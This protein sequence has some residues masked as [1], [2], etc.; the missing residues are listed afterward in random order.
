MAIIRMATENEKHRCMEI[1]DMLMEL[2]RDDGGSPIDAISDAVSILS[3]VLVLSVKP[4]HDDD[5]MTQILAALPISVAKIRLAN[6]P[7]TGES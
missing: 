6:V 7:I 2:V 4:H 5:I 3:M 1:A